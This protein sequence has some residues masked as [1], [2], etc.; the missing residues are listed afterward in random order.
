VAGDAA[1]L[2]DP[3]VTESIV[4]AV[5]RV[6]DDKEYAEAQRQLGLERSRRFDW[7]EAARQTVACY[8]RVLGT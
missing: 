3:L 7:D 5:E 1:T 4:A 8:R 2:V 6:L